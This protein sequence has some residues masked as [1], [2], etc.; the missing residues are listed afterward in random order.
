[1][2]ETNLGSFLKKLRKRM[3]LSQEALAT[4]LGLQRQSYSHYET[5]RNKPPVDILIRLSKI[6]NIPVEAFTQLTDDSAPSLAPSSFLLAEENGQYVVSNSSIDLLK[7]M[8]LSAKETD[9]INHF[10]LLDNRDQYD[11]L[12]ITKLKV[13]ISEKNAPKTEH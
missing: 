9:L 2:D 3:N 13:K 4:Q 8:N 7:Y 5:G 6:Y 11:V 1:M 12:Q 10:R